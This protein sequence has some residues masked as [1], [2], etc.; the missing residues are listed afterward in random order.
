[1]NESITL[2]SII[3]RVDADC[4]NNGGCNLPNTTDANCGCFRGYS[5]SLCEARIQDTQLPFFVIHL[6]IFI[7]VFVAFFTLG[8]LNTISAIIMYRRRSGKVVDWTIILLFAFIAIGSLD[9]ILWLCIDPYW[10]YQIMPIPLENI[11]YGLGQ[12]SIVAECI[13]VVSAWSV[14]YNSF[15]AK[16][17]V[18]YVKPICIAIILI[19]LIGSILQD[20]F[21]QSVPSSRRGIFSIVYSVALLVACVF[22]CAGFLIYGR[23]LYGALR[24]FKNES[25]NVKLMRKINSITNS[26]AIVAVVIAFAIAIAALARIWFRTYHTFLAWETLF[27]LIEAGI[28]LVILQ[29]FSFHKYYATAFCNA[30]MPSSTSTGTYSRGG[31]PT[32]ATV[33]RQTIS[34]GQDTQDA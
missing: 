10:A 15:N 8:V 19:L 16:P 9:R 2:P 13:L 28:H 5:G 7:P 33:S 21:R 24:M 29:V 27:R 23:R 34:D 20:G 4:L 31:S 6:V 32:T 14:V 25:A 22:V 1:M 12:W 18:R 17:W 3:C 26:V 11:L 30:P